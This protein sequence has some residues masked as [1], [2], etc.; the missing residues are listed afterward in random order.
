MMHSIFS[1]CSTLLE[2]T[3]FNNLTVFMGLGITLVLYVV[4]FVTKSHQLRSYV[5]TV[6][7]SLGIFFTFCAIYYGLKGF[8]PKTDVISKLI[9]EINKAFT[10]SI[11]GIAG[12]VFFCYS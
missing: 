2:G 11:I 3:N 5:P 12:A 8:D 1:Y 10:T 4:S 6:W 9:R 7:T